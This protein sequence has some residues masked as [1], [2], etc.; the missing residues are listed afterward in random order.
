MITRLNT[1]EGVPIGT[2]NF[3]E[4][5]SYLREFLG[6]N[7]GFST[8]TITNNGGYF[9]ADTFVYNFIGTGNPAADIYVF[10]PQTKS[11]GNLFGRRD[12]EFFRFEV[13]KA[14][15]ED[16]QQVHKW[17]L[18]ATDSEVIS[19][20]Y[21]FR[22]VS[23]APQERMLPYKPVRGT[24]SGGFSYGYHDVR[25]NGIPQTWSL[26]YTPSGSFYDQS[27]SF[28]KLSLGAEYPVPILDGRYDTTLLTI[29]TTRGYLSSYYNNTVAFPHTNFG[30]D[31]GGHIL[32]MR[33]SGG[34][35]SYVYVPQDLSSNVEPGDGMYKLV[36]ASRGII[37]LNITNAQLSELIFPSEQLSPPPLSSIL[38][39]IVSAEQL[40]SSIVNGVSTHSTRYGAVY[41]G[42][43]ANVRLVSYVFDGQLH[44]V[45]EID[46]GELSSTVGSTLLSDPIGKYGDGVIL[47]I[48]YD[49]IVSKDILTDVQVNRYEPDTFT[50]YYSV[51]V[52]R[53]DVS[54]SS[55]IRAIVEHNN[56]SFYNRDILGAEY[57]PV[58]R[59]RSTGY[60]LVSQ[61]EATLL[62]NAFNPDSAFQIVDTV[63]LSSL[64]DVPA[65][66]DGDVLVYNGTTTMFDAVE[67]TLANLRDVTVAGSVPNKNIL[68]YSTGSNKWIN[69]TVPNALG[70]TPVNKAGDTGIGGLLKYSPGMSGFDNNSLITKSYVDNYII[71]VADPSLF[72]PVI[73]GQYAVGTGSNNTAVGVSALADGNNSTSIG[74]GAQAYAGGVSLGYGASVAGGG[75]SVGNVA[76]PGA[77]A[78]SIVVGQDATFGSLPSAG[79]GLSNTIRRKVIAIGNDISFTSQPSYSSL[80]PGT[81]GVSTI[82]IGDN[83][84]VYHGVTS[85]SGG[86]GYDAPGASVAIGTNASITGGAGTALGYSATA[87]NSAVAVGK[88][89]L[90]SGASS[91]SLGASSVAS[92]LRATALGYDSHASADRA[93]AINGN[94]TA[95][96]STAIGKGH[97]APSTY[98]DSSATGI[99]SIALGG[100]TASNSWTFA[101][102][103]QSSAEG[104]RSIALGY[105]AKV[106]GTTSSSSIA[107]GDGAEVTSHL[108]VAIGMNAS[109]QSTSVS[110]GGYAQVSSSTGFSV[111]VGYKAKVTAAISGIAIGGEAE[112]RSIRSIAVGETA[113]ATS[114]YGVAIGSAASAS[115]DAVAIGKNT[116]ADV[117]A[118]AL[119]DDASGS[120]TSS[121]AIGQRAQAGTTGVAIGLNAATGNNGIVIGANAKAVYTGSNSPIIAIGKDTRANGTIPLMMRFGLAQAAGWTNVYLVYDASDSK[122]KFNNGSGTWR[123]LSSAP[124]TA[125]TLPT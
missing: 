115:V 9:S 79:G 39:T 94:A 120:G 41:N 2:S 82:A 17:T 89:S 123:E 58:S 57:Y 75:I 36:D 19:G 90:A 21:T 107:I 25:F 66:D 76:A 31:Y 114:G 52:I 102:G 72:N 105:A 87:N 10:A 88:Y 86:G 99:S 83:V 98:L 51:G 23:T 44:I 97:V 3:D 63:M 1:Y 78:G 20:N 29:G 48:T 71:S 122:F 93:T 112:A 7:F 53:N 73:I 47:A 33:V 27:L 55:D 84:T 104:A 22:N 116:T 12:G 124:T 62:G 26:S 50:L 119:G 80:G 32:L 91:V 96:T 42:N 59:S 24:I 46:Q 8:N 95:H 103:A 125:P 40:Q 118:V 85:F 15:G 101:A 61:A 30:I 117:Y 38:F 56:T 121:I 113:K 49:A 14:N 70:F 28:S 74:H 106:T 68:M 5:L 77:S 65:L 81:Y 92:G 34:N 54:G 16:A 6:A 13:L 111:A 69:S 35:R 18:L 60:A 45:N 110:V 4:F 108:G 64:G 37:K 100:G 67:F 11:V 43:T 109:T